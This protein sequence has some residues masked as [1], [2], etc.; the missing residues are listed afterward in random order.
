MMTSSLDTGL[1][2]LALLAR[3]HGIA[4]DPDSLKHEYATHQAPLGADEI[5]LTVHSLGAVHIC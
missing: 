4:V 2:C 5:L 1:G 3:F